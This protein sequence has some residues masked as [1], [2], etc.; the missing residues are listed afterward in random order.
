M[1]FI[2]SNNPCANIDILNYLQKSIINID[3]K[4]GTTLNEKEVVFIKQMMNENP[5][6]FE[7][8]SFQINEIL[9]KKK[10]EISDIP[11]IIHIICTVYTE[12]FDCKN[13]NIINCVEFTL[14]ALIESNTLFNDNITKEILRP[15][16]DFSFGLL[17]TNVSFIEENIEVATT[18]C[19]NMFRCCK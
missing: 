7:K 10:F 11:Q 17:K 16:V 14:D 12:D 6:T 19:F 4:E 18:S 13:V 8:V 3:V 2:E 9:A 5:A 1:E 15:V